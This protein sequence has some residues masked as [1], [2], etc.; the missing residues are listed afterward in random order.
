M[1]II[2]AANKPKNTPINKIPLLTNKNETTNTIT[3][4][5]SDTQNGIEI[6]IVI[7]FIKNKIHLSNPEINLY[8][9]CLGSLIITFSLL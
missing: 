3:N 2:I 7:H 8:S 4:E 9:E 6:K 5:I 1:L